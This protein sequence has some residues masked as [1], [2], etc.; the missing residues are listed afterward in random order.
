MTTVRE[1]PVNSAILADAAAGLFARWGR[2]TTV[3]EHGGAAV[4]E[5]SVVRELHGLAG[6]PT[7]GTVGNAGL[8]HVYGYLLSNA[9][10]PYGPKHARWTSGAVARALGV[11][12][13]ALLPDPPR[14]RTG[15]TPLAA[16][17]PLLE[18]LLAAPPR[19]AAVVDEFGDGIRARTVLLDGPGGALLAYGVATRRCAGG[20][21]GAGE[22]DRVL[23]VTVFPI[24]DVSTV[25]CSVEAE[26]PRLRYN[27][28]DASGRAGTAL[29]ERDVRRL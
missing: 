17:T 12:A 14:D 25:L 18:R 1:H 19:A 23:P 28:V 16:L 5:P 29:R 8:V 6:L 4:L 7:D 3:D 27:A 2:S 11:E 9:E 21:S 13:A 20:A 26:P 15:R 22:P 10:T 24:D